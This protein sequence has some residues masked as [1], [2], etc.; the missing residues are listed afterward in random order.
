MS[1]VFFER[2]ENMYDAL[3]GGY[4]KQ[5][6][7]TFLEENS[8]AALAVVSKQWGVQVTSVFYAVEGDM[9]ILIKSHVTSDHG[10]EMMLNNKVSLAIYDKQSSYSQKKGMQLRGICERITDA[11]EMRNAVKIYSDRFEGAAARFLPI[12]ELISEDVK[13]TL[14]RIKIQ[15]GKMIT[16]EGYSPEFQE[17]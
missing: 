10:K 8:V 5:D 15:S 7:Q 2:S 16:P 3:K 9:S 1:Y 4:N 12:E 13:S 11:E 17:F 14:F 6:F